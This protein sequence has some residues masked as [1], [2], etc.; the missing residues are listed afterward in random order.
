MWE[1]NWSISQNIPIE[2]FHGIESDNAL[3]KNIEQQ[4]E[5]IMSMGKHD[6]I[7]IS[8]GPTSS[9]HSASKRGDQMF[10]LKYYVIRFT[11]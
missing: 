8:E 10:M 2:Q 5:T 3:L 4:Q 7:K 6:I 11:K 9:R 1:P